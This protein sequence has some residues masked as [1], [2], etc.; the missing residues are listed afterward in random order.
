MGLFDFFKPKKNPMQE[1]FENMN[2]NMFPK[3]D[4]DISAA[5][6]ELLN[7][8]HYKIEREEAKSII[9]RAIPL[10]RIAKEFS[11]ARLRVHLEGY[12]LQHFNN[13]QVGKFYYE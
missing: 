9:L 8:L 7:I 12:C 4:K 10:S 13:E 2:N 5:T 11:E 3:Q 6:D 1:L